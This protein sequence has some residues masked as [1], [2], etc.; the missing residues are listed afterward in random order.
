M[1]FINMAKRRQFSSAN[2]RLAK[3]LQRRDRDVTLPVLERLCRRGL[4][5]LRA[6]HH[7]ACATA[8]E[9]RVFVIQSGA[10]R[11]VTW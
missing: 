11:P 1:C 4:D 10:A 3:C 5:Q 8:S 2:K 6:L 9:A 7:H